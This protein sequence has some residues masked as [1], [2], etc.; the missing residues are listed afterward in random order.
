MNYLKALILA[1]FIEQ[2]WRTVLR[3]RRRIRKLTAAGVPF[4]SRR[5]FRLTR[6][7]SRC[8]QI[9]TYC[10]DYYEKYFANTVGGVL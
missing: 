9:I 1:R 3:G 4:S 2:N 8:R 5:I 10:N 6:K 7:V